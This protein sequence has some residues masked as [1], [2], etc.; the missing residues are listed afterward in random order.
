MHKQEGALVVI[1]LAEALWG[2]LVVN[3]E[4]G[5]GKSGTKS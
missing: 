2:G 4:K 5:N 3:I 1:R